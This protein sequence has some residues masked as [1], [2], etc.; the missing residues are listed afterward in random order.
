MNAVKGLCARRENQNFRNNLIGHANYV[1]FACLGIDSAINW[2]KYNAESGKIPGIS[3]AATAVEKFPDVIRDRVHAGTIK[4]VGKYNGKSNKKLAKLFDMGRGRDEARARREYEERMD[5]PRALEPH[6]EVYDGNRNGFFHQGVFIATRRYIPQFRSPAFSL[7]ISLRIESNKHQ[8]GMF[9]DYDDVKE[10]FMELLKEDNV[11]YQDKFKAGLG[12]LK[13]KKMI[14]VEGRAPRNRIRI[15]ENGEILADRLLRHCSDRLSNCNCIRLYN[16]R[17]QHHGGAAIRRSSNQANVPPRANTPM[18]NRNGQRL[19]N[20]LDRHDDD[21]DV[22]MYDGNEYEEEM[23]ENMR[24]DEGYR[25]R[26]AQAQPQTRRVDNNENN[27]A[28]LYGYGDMN[29]DLEEEILENIRNDEAFRKREAQSQSQPQARNTRRLTSPIHQNYAH[30]PTM[31]QINTP[32]PPKPPTNDTLPKGFNP[33]DVLTADVDISKL[34]FDTHV[35]SPPQRTPIRKSTSAPTSKST[36]KSRKTA[37]GGRILGGSAS[38]NLHSMTPQQKRELLAL[39]SQKR[40]SVGPE[41]GISLQAKIKEQEPTFKQPR[42]GGITG[43]HD[44]YQNGGDNNDDWDLK[45]NPIVSPEKNSENRT[46][47]RFPNQRNQ[48]DIAEWDIKSSPKETPLRRISTANS[49][50][51]NQFQSR[52]VDGWVIKPSPS[53][54]RP[55]RTSLPNSNHKSKFQSTPHIN[56]NNNNNADDDDGWNIKPSPRK[57][58]LPKDDFRRRN[59]W[60][61]TSS[62]PYHGVTDSSVVSSTDSSNFNYNHN[63]DNNQTSN[64]EQPREGGIPHNDIGIPDDNME[65]IDQF[66]IDDDYG[67]SDNY[68][69]PIDEVSVSKPKIEIID[70]MEYFN[71]C[72]GET[73]ISGDKY[74]INEEGWETPIDIEIIDDMKI[75]EKPVRIEIESNNNNSDNNKRFTMNQTPTRRTS[76]SQPQRQRQIMNETKR[77]A[78]YQND[79]IEDLTDSFSLPRTSQT[80]KSRQPPYSQPDREVKTTI[81][82]GSTQL[83]PSN[84]QDNDY[85]EDLTIEEKPMT[86]QNTLRTTSIRRPQSYSQPDRGVKTKV[87]RTRLPV[88]NHHQNQPGINDPSTAGLRGSNNHNQFG[89]EATNPP[90]PSS[91][92]T[93]RR[94]NS[95]NTPQPVRNASHVPHIQLQNA[96]QHPMTGDDSP[97]SV[98][99]TIFGGRESPSLP[100]IDISL[101]RNPDDWEVILVVDKREKRSF[102]ARTF[103]TDQLKSSHVTCEMKSLNLGDFLWIARPSQKARDHLGR[104][105]PNVEYVLDFIIERKTVDDFQLS[106]IDKRYGEQKQRL[107]ESKIRHVIYLVEGNLEELRGQRSLTAKAMESFIHRT[108]VVSGFFVKETVNIHDSISYLILLH[109]MISDNFRRSVRYGTAN[110]LHFEEFQKNSAKDQNPTV[111]VLL[112]NMLR[113]VP[114]TSPGLTGSL[115]KLCP[116]PRLLHASLKQSGPLSLQDLKS[117]HGI[118]R[119]GPMFSQNMHKVITTKRYSSLSDVDDDDNDENNEVSP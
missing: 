118:K 3:R 13:T 109:R 76:Y 85:I 22:D 89:S 26:Q 55:N 20:R 73:S 80:P 54:T 110:G 103:I 114:R 79:H 108:T 9:L 6:N 95:S 52:D 64:N 32:N 23:L 92:R 11:D 44:P 40:L 69:E 17:H 72:K 65:G 56:S 39:K 4:N 90:T 18:G 77:R 47:N 115:V 60:Q 91:Q 27:D 82:R 16:N 119:A 112:G 88:S 12:T 70:G 78:T 66:G 96:I 24:N 93:N 97:C 35:P 31:G 61:S 63:R 8:Q 98:S 36:I 87:K 51:K 15:I 104:N 5:R 94:M 29:M 116:T 33:G 30:Y 14:E 86:D 48:P 71:G 74:Y 25:R 67:M 10:S 50:H 117:K 81:K 68:M 43:V 46:M 59:R 53:K 45:Q 99:R 101:L 75:E 57:T 100:H 62:T 38:V 1:A 19:G 21:N 111:R 34:G 106:I 83:Q 41:K 28:L 113:Q 2:R 7:I 58:S 49:N 37:D 102:T 84:H 105:C 107:L 42:F